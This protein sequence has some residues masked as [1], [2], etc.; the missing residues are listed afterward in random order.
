MENLNQNKR[1]LS[2]HES[3]VHSCN[4]RFIFGDIIIMPTSNTHQCRWVCMTVTV[5]YHS[6]PCRGWAVSVI[7]VQ[8][9]VDLSQIPGVVI[10]GAPWMFKCTL[11]A[12]ILLMKSFGGPLTL[13]P[14]A[15]VR[16]GLHN[17]NEGSTIVDSIVI[18]P[19]FSMS[20]LGNWHILKRWG[21]FPF[22]CGCPDPPCCKRVGQYTMRI[23]SRGR[24]YVIKNME[25]V[26]F[27][28][29]HLLHLLL[30][31]C[32]SPDRAWDCV[33][34]RSWTIPWILWC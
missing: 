25:A 16:Y 7:G 12:N 4:Q 22:L 33:L 34:Y 5:L 13:H 6:M 32:N 15:C 10:F 2:G 8:T 18:S 3:S 11:R 29:D 26:E 20:Y 17:S 14:C 9:S 23:L 24:G 30:D 19:M 28:L 27:L 21:I 1:P 31:L